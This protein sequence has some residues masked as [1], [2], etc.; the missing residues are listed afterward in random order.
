MNSAHTAIPTSPAPTDISAFESPAAPSL[1]HR[2]HED[3]LGLLTG[4]LFVAL[5]AMLFSDARLLTGGTAGLALLISY[6]MGWAFG[7][8][9]FAVNLP[10]YLFAW[11]MMGRSFTLRT[12][13]AVSLMSL[14]SWQLPQVIGLDHL[15][16][17]FAA[18]LGG[19]LVGTGLLILFRH[20][21]SLGGINVVALFLQNR[22][23]W[24]AG[25]VQLVIDSLIVLA[26]FSVTDAWHVALSVLG[27]VVLNMTL[28]INHRPGRYMAV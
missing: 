4:T 1:A 20:Q 12:V 22:W 3:V 24:R 2:A 19:L 18:I 5:G 8:V 27:A 11:K 26:A 9:F 23:G 6:T 28:A 10:F 21:A 13:A 16:P 15:S 25:R 17:T 7:P 14:I